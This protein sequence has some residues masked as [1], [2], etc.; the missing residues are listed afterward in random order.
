MYVDKHAK[1]PQYMSL[2]ELFT[3]TFH[4]FSSHAARFHIMLK[5]CY[6]VKLK[7]MSYH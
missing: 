2:T 7:K 3:F 1:M 6:K 4:V 5:A